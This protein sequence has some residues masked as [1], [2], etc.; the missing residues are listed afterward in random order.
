MRMRLQALAKAPSVSREAPARTYRASTMRAPLSRFN[1]TRTQRPAA[2]A[3]Y[4]NAAAGGRNVVRDPPNST[5]SSAIAADSWKPLGG[6]ASDNRL[7]SRYL[8]GPLN[9]TSKR[10]ALPMTAAS[11]R[12]MLSVPSSTARQAP[13]QA[14]ARS[15]VPPTGTYRDNPVRTQRYGSMGP[16]SVAA[17]AFGNEPEVGFGNNIA[18]RRGAEPPR[19]SY[20][21]CAARGLAVDGL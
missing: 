21:A 4:T 18:K 13:T 7:L 10:D 11:S 14:P 17:A 6:V 2:G 1:A 19:K 16:T 20:S 12:T 5:N 9:S 3:A 15:V 8:N